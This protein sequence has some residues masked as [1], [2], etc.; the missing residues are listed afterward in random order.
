MR[1][2]RSTSPVPTALARRIGNTRS[3]VQEPHSALAPTSTRRIV[4]SR[5]NTYSAAGRKTSAVPNKALH[6]TAA[7]SLGPALKR[8]VHSGLRPLRS[9]QT[10]ARGQVSAGR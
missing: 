4:V 2:L 1:W 8:L 10:G 9:R 6:L 5:I 3:T 7:R